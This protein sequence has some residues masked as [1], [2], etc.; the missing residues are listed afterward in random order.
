[1]WHRWFTL[2]SRITSLWSKRKL[3]AEF[4]QELE[5][6]RDAL[7]EEYRRAGLDETEARRAAILKLGG[8]A[9]LEEDRR[10]QQGFPLLDAVLRDLRVALRFVAKSPG[11]T[12]VAIATLAI[13]IGANTAMFS[14]VDAVLLRPLPYA[15]PG[16]LV[17]I[18]ETNPIR[19]WTHATVAPAN[20]SDWQRMNAVFTGIAA[21][22]GTDGKGAGNL[23]V[24]L[25]GDGEPRRLKALAATGNLFDVLRVRPLLGRTFTDDE[26]FEDR[27][28]VVVLSYGLWQSAF[29]ADPQI[30]GRSITLSGRPYHVIGVMPSEFFFPSHDVQIYTGFHASHKFFAEN[31]RP[32]MLGVVARLRDGV[33]I[34][35]ARDQMNAVASRLEQMYPDTNTRMGVRLESFH[36]SLAN[37]SRPALLLL[38]GAVGFLFLIVC[39]NIANLQL[40]RAASRGREMNIRRALGASRLALIRQLLIE[41]LVLSLAGGALGLLLAVAARAALLQYA[42]DA[43]PLYADL[44]ISRWAVAFN[45]AVSLFAPLVFGIAPAIFSS[46]GVGLKDHGSTEARGGRSIRNFLVAA[47]VA[48]CVVLVIGAG[49]LIRSLIRLTHVDPG[50]KGEQVISFNLVLPS[51]RY[52]EDEQQL[53]AIQDIEDRLRAMPQVISVGATSKLALRGSYWTGDATVEGKNQ[54]ERELRHKAVTPEYFR[55]MGTPLISGRFLDRSDGPKGQITLVNEALARSYFGGRDPVGK[56]MKFGRPQDSDPWMTVVGVV[57]N[58]KQDSLA[59][60][61]QPEVYVPI[62]QEPAGSMTFVLRTAGDPAGVVTAARR[63]VQGFDKD[64]ALTDVISLDDLVR[65]SVGGERLRTWLLAGFAA[66]ALLL[67]VIGVYGVLSYS[68]NQ[69]VREIGIRAAL[70]ADPVR[71]FGMILKQGMHPVLIGSAAGLITAA[72]VT[73]LMRSLLFGVQPGDLPTYFATALL[74]AAVALAA[75][76]APAWKAVQVDPAI[77]LRDE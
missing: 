58:Q 37:E 47:Q 19:G 30:V 43:L 75:C 26:T 72:A 20:F 5:S 74:L 49:L 40:G 39:V 63:A 18:T 44:R 46:R 22:M 13:G 64:L 16:R 55:T 27:D 6:H 29:A 61:D 31:R 28:R 71:L 34:G 9:Q 23:D 67:A 66:V 52:P 70:G 8:P 24:F 33:S 56:R 12:L 62:T 57:A 54:A 45:V 59:V 36:S 10:D 25:T 65:D 48:L 21:Y 50:F 51:V 77:T 41:S 69:R 1:M 14:V 42:P 53:R 7:V 32:H 4:R 73:Q 11:F 3:D 2:Q 76:S 68:V 15:Q 38:F 60:A 17:E 35:Q